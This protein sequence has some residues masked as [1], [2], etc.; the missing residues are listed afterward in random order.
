MSWHGGRFLTVRGHGR[1]SIAPFM[2]PG[3]SREIGLGQSTPAPD[4]EGAGA[5]RGMAH[6]PDGTVYLISDGDPAILAWRSP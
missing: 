6:G 1:G 3:A 2:D 5:W 4:I